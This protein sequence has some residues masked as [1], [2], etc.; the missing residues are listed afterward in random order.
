VGKNVKVYSGESM[1]KQAGGVENCGAVA[2]WFSP[3]G[4]VRNRKAG[5]DAPAFR[6]VM[7]R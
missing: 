3:S 7:Y 2:A 4:R 1:L 6:G 5:A